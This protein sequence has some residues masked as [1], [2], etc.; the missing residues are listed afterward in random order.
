[1][2]KG[3]RF[4]LIAA[5]LTASATVQAPVKALGLQLDGFPY[6]YQVTYLQLNIQKQNL[7]MAYMDAKPQPA[8]GKTVLLLHGKNF[9]GAYWDSTAKA[10]TEQ[11]YRVIMPDQI[12]FG[13]SS[14][15]STLEYTVHL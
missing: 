3:I 5:I 13:K 6:P 1:M 15:P 11:G 2:K 4:L 9:S 10:V 8:N 14:K 7:Q 12:G